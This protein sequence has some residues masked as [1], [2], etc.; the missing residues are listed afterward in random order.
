MQRTTSTGGWAWILAVATWG[1][2]AAPSAWANSDLCRQAG[3]DK[4]GYHLTVETRD[5]HNAGTDAT[6]TFR[7][8]GEAYGQR[9]NHVLSR[10]FIVFGDPK[11]VLGATS[12]E[13]YLEQGKREYFGPLCLEDRLERILSVTISTDGSG[14]APGWFGKELR[15][16]SPDGWEFVCPIGSWLEDKPILAQCRLADCKPTPPGRVAGWPHGCYCGGTNMVGAAVGTAAYPHWTFICASARHAGVID[17]NGGAVLYDLVGKGLKTRTLCGP[18]LG[19]ERLI[20]SS[21]VR[22][23]GASQKSDSTIYFPA[24]SSPSCQ[25]RFESDQAFIID[26]KNGPGLYLGLDLDTE[27]GILR[28]SLQRSPIGIRPEFA[29]KMKTWIMTHDPSFVVQYG[30]FPDLQDLAFFIA[31]PVFRE[32]R[33]RMAHDLGLCPASSGSGLACAKE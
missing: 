30:L 28:T 20:N 4:N 19:S 17:E 7:V 22:S 18:F 6:L 27:G 5:V 14:T 25:Q 21:P 3:S 26:N 15:I 29:Q 8:T 31:A 24:A 16:T 32:A 12:S 13:D 23:V 9:E 11:H 10:N 2:L 1:L 33:R